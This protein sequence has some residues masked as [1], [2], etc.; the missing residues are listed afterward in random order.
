MVWQDVFKIL[1]MLFVGVLG[2]PVTQAIKLGLSN[3]LGKPVEDR[4]ALL[5]TG[6][7]SAVFALLEMW[8]SGTLDFSTITVEN[9]P[10]AFFGVFTL[11][12]LYY[13]W[14]KGSDSLLGKRFLLKP[15]K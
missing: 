9:F 15:V 14:L 12:T 3:L 6:A 1:I 8:L 7:V 5:L 2:A 13:G 4:W 11:A 10:T